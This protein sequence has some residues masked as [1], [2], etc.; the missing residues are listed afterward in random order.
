[1]KLDAVK[2][3]N[4]ARLVREQ[5]AILSPDSRAVLGAYGWAWYPN[6]AN[7]RHMGLF[8]EIRRRPAG[9]NT[10][11]PLA[12]PVF[13]GT[14]IVFRTGRQPCRSPL[15]ASRRARPR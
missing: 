2:G 13:Y 12:D 9:N 7:L 6:T 3:S 1:M 4:E 15:V 10:V 5:D 14:C 11:A 8:F